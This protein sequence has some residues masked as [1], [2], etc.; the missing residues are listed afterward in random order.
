MEVNNK[1]NCGDELY[2]VV[3][4]PI[5]YDCPVCDGSGIFQ[6]NGYDVK[7]PH[8]CGSGKVHDGKTLWCVADEKVKIRRIIAS[9]WED[10]ITCKY[11]VNY[12]GT[13]CN[14]NNRSENNLFVNKEDAENWCK[15]NNNQVISE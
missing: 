13:D 4:K 6:H 11:K 9:I 12:S 15:E 5:K 8:C 7:C 2:T 10:Q 14:I 3:R 1:Y